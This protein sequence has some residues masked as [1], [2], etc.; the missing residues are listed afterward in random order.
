MWV[1]DP[2]QTKMVPR[3]SKWIGT[4]CAAATFCGQMGSVLTGGCQCGR[5]RFRLDGE[6]RDVHYCH[7]SMCRRAVGNAF[8]TLVWVPLDRLRWLGAQPA[9]W[10]SS[11]IAERGFC[12]RCGSPG[13]L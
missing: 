3:V 7:C 8:A 5:I 10:R 12:G 13:F 4:S 6:P 2:G 1:A 11:A 9:V